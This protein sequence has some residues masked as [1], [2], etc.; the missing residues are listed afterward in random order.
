MAPH[1]VERGGF[2]AASQLL[3]IFLD[4]FTQ[5]LGVRERVEDPKPRLLTSERKFI[6]LHAKPLVQKAGGGGHGYR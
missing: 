2:P 6:G 5:T 3:R 4:V 1:T